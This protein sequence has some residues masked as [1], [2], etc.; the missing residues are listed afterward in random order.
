MELL[1]LGEGPAPLLCF[2]TSLASFSEIEEQCLIPAGQTYTLYC[3]S[4]ADAETLL[5]CTASPRQRIERHSAYERAIVHQIAPLIQRT[6][7]RPTFGVCGV[8]LGGYQAFNFAMRHPDLV[9]AC[10]TFGAPFDLRGFFRG[11]FDEDVYYHNPVEYLP[12]L[13]DPW[14]INRYREMRIVL[15]AGE[16][17]LY[18]GENHRMSGILHGKSISHWLDVWGQGAGHDWVWWRQMAQKHFT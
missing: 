7:G 8:G 16:Q 17:D 5:D 12:N 15:T 10:V 13:A 11:Y 3:A 2:P 6:S 9:H 14:F 1:V 18:V 4:S